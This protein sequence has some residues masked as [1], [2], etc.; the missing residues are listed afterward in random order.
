MFRIS[1]FS[2]S[3]DIIAMVGLASLL[4]LC[5]M[6]YFFPIINS[7]TLFYTIGL[8]SFCGLSYPFLWWKL[9]KDPI[10]WIFNYVFGNQRA[11][12]MFSIWIICILCAFLIVM[13]QSSKATTVN[14]K[15]FHALVVIV[16]TSGIL[17]D[18]NFLYLSSIVSLCIMLL[19]EHIRFHK[20]EPLAA[21][22][23]RSFQAFKDD[24]DVGDLVLTNL[25]LLAGVSLPLWISNDLT[26]AN[27]V[28]LLSGVL[29]IGVGDS[30]ASIIGSKWGRIKLIPY[31]E[32]TL[33]GLI[34]SKWG[35]IKLMMP[36]TEK[37]VEGLIASVLSQVIFVKL[38][39]I[40][41]FVNFRPILI[42]SIFV[43]SVLETIT[44]QVDNLAL[45]LVM[46]ILNS[47]L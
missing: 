31:T 36:Y 41:N 11:L 17:I 46:Y 45:P 32:K 37:T 6:S 4:I 19:L 27:S 35:K 10:M 22:L 40:G 44:T 3:F 9:K 34:A 16:Y 2:G 26:Q 12:S 21:I 39:Q 33:E 23:N 47:I 43:T 15:Y 7:P 25:Y 5:L 8:A 24:K 14:R 20:I 42:I 13:N 38:L 1:R 29:S 30:F 18:V 28:L